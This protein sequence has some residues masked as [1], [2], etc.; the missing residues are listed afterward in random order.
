MNFKE[1]CSS[2]RHNACV[3][4]V[5]KT[6]EGDAEI[7]IVDGNEAYLGSFAMDSYEKHEFIPNS[8]YTDYLPKNLNFE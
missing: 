2:I 3:L 6:S 5:K 4:S 7:R 1:M 8:L